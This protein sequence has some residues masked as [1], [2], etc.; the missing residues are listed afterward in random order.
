MELKKFTNDVAQQFL[1]EDQNKVSETI[2][3]RNLETYDS[4]TGMAIL[5]VI[6]DE[7]GINI[8]VEEYLKLNTI[9][10]LFEYVNKRM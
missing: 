8:P 9:K 6:N 3:F 5:A 4:L 10:Q 1:D 2:K 7:Y